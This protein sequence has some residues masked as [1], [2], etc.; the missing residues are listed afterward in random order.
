MTYLDDADF[1]HI[2]K[3]IN[4]ESSEVD[5]R[6]FIEEKLRSVL[7]ALDRDTL[8]ASAKI[9]LYHHFV[10][11]KLSWSLLINDLCLT[12]VKKLQAIATKLLR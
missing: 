11:S 2:G 9:W 3:P 5:C 4:T 10:A 8:T 6:M 7:E 12:F 1:R